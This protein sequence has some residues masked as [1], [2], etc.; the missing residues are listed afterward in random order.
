MVR[1]GFGF[2]ISEVQ[3]AYFLAALQIGLFD[4]DLGAFWCFFYQPGVKGLCRGIE[5]LTVQSLDKFPCSQIP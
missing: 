2:G 5:P 3:F 1:F 4:S